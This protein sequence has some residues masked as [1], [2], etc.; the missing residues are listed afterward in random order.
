YRG[1]FFVISLHDLGLAYRKA[2]VDLYYS[3]SASLDAIADY[4]EN[5]HKN[6]CTLQEKIQSDDESWVTE[7]EFIGDWT[8][9]PKTVKMSC[10]EQYRKQHESGLK[11]SSP[12]EE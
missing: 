6:L 2:K 10:L 4:E 1:R 12:A 9:A 3:S 8:L 11:F 7:R 5:L